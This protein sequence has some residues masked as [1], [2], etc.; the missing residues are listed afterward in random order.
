MRRVCFAPF[1]LCAVLTAILLVGPLPLA[2]AISYTGDVSSGGNPSPDHLD[3]W[4]QWLC[5]QY[6]H[7]YPDG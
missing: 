2:H 7:G 4:H 3:Q 6:R 5:W 1:T